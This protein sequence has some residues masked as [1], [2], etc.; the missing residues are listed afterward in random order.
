MSD[1]NLELPKPPPSPQKKKGGTP[2]LQILIL[3][4]L[5]A[6]IAIQLIPSSHSRITNVQINS[7]NSGLPFDED[8]LLRLEKAG[9]HREAART[10]STALAS[11]K[12]SQERKTELLIRRARLLNLAGDHEAA[13]ADFYRAEALKQDASDT[14]LNKEIL[15]TLRRMGRFDAASDELR[16]INRL[17]RSDEKDRTQS[18]PILAKVDG[19]ELKMSEFRKVIDL[20]IEQKLF[21]LPKQGLDADALTKAKEEITQQMA[22]PGERW[23]ALQEWVSS[24]VLYREALLWKLDSSPEFLD[25]MENL[26]RAILGQMIVTQQIEKALPREQDIENELKA[27]PEKYG[28]SA[29]TQNW[30]PE[31]Q[32]TALMKAKAQYLETW[33]QERQQAF[34]KDLMERHKVEVFREVFEEGAP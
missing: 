11:K 24:E 15:N 17:Q 10:L 33:Q 22:N 5:I 8:V 32:N 9:A 26:R 21:A 2:V 30:T 12:I 18:D 34:Q 29:N 13:L 6:L 23:K 4:A 14:E 3:I 28:P 25:R 19:E 16:N 1:L 20:A 27:N 31:Q 7:G